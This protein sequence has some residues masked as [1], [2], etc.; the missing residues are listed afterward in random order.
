MSEADWMMT[1]LRDSI[2]NDLPFSF[3]RVRINLLLRYYYFLIII[4][5]QPLIEATIKYIKPLII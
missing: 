4:K 3:I 1:L 5:F 2:S